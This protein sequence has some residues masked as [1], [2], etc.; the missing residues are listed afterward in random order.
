MN[1]T[2]LPV[3][4]CLTILPCLKTLAGESHAALEVVV[5]PPAFFFFFDE[6]GEYGPLISSSYESSAVSMVALASTLFSPLRFEGVCE[7]NGADDEGV[8]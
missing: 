7:P 5:R 6:G 8:G 1:E 2:N 3:H 4:I